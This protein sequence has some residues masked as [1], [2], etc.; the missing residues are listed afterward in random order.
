MYQW[1]DRAP[2]GRNETVLVQGM[3][4]SAVASGYAAMTS[5][6]P[7][8]AG[9]RSVVI[10]P[11]QATP[12]SSNDKERKETMTNHKTGTRE[13]WL[14]ARLELLKA[15]KELTRRSDEL[16][17]QRQELPWV[18]IDK[19]YR[20]ETDEGT[21]RS[22]TSSEGARSSSSTTSCSGPTTPQV[23][24]LL[25]DRGRVQRLR[26]PP[27]EPRRHACGGVAGAAREAAGVQTADGW[28]FPWA[29]S[30][31]SDFNHDFNVRSPRSNSAGRQ[32][33]TTTARVAAWRA[34]DRSRD[35]DEAV[36]RSRP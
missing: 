28:S 8:D 3:V 33:N 20:F 11:V 24:G 25:G 4:T 15:E 31:G 13:Q 10:A 30:F 5:T 36:A 17:R 29:S 27:G 32:S 18:R 22:P 1:L 21:P 26:R 9:G 14:A 12:S 2:R 35:A 16:A 6:T 19:E 7:V 34:T 23:S